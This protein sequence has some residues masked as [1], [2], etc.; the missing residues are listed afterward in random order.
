MMLSHSTMPALARPL[1]TAH[2]GALYSAF[3]AMMLTAGVPAFIAALSL[4][5]MSNLFGSITHFGKGAKSSMIHPA[6]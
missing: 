2:V 3:L 1:Q 5:F 6:A 4:G